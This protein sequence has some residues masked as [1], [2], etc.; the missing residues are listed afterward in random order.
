MF[1]DSVVVAFRLFLVCVATKQVYLHSMRHKRE[2]DGCQPINN[3]I[4]F[5]FVF[6]FVFV[7]IFG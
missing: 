7:I 6:V 5:S 1:F 3:R 2:T 4:G